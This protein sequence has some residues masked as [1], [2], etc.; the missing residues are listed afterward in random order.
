MEYKTNSNNNNNNLYIH[1]II[2]VSRCIMRVT[3]RSNRTNRT[4]TAPPPPYIHVYYNNNTRVYDDDR[5]KT[6][7]RINAY[8]CIY[9][10]L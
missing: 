1:N 4:I 5:D 7:C 3:S 10:I 6:S 2:H 8:I 9:V